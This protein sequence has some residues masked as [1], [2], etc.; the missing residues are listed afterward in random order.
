MDRHHEVA[1]GAQ[2]SH[3]LTRDHTAPASLVQ[4]DD[5]YLHE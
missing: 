3:V 4:G 2:R 5:G 1:P